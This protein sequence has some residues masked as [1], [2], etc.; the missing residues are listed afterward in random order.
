MNIPAPTPLAEA[1]AHVERFRP[2]LV[3]MSGPTILRP[4]GLED[5]LTLPLPPREMVCVPWLPAAGLAM[6]FAPRGVGMTHV[7]LGLAYAVASGSQFLK[8]HAPKPRRVLVID[9]EMP[10][11][12]LQERLIAIRQAS[13]L[14]PPSDDYLRVLASDLHRDGLPDLSDPSNHR[15]YEEAIGD[16]EVIIAD[17]LSTLCRS[18]RENDAESW[19]P[20]QS[21]ALAQRRA[22][23]SVLFVHHGGKGG[24]QRGTSR[25]EDILDTVVSLRRPEDYSPVEGARFEVHFEKSR[26]FS[27]ADAEPFEAALTT[28][29]WT[30]RDLN[31]ALE[32]RVMAFRADGLTQ[33]EIASEIGI[34]V[35]TVN[36]LVKR[37]QAKRTE[38]QD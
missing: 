16:A 38:A 37:A 28:S 20:V 19:L 32:D 27:G 34:S 36:A 3:G 21:W 35:G 30:V 6:L 15:H 12:A 2:A 29:G 24:A 10:A 23:R 7:A 26:G 13:S 4:I 11:A 31:D 17:N 8:W 14:K 5:F 22:H 25:K 18:G 9:G 33:R 1:V